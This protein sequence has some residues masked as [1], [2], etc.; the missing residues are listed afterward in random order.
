VWDASCTNTIASSYLELAVKGRGQV[1]RPAAL[2][3]INKYRNISEDYIF[4][5]F[6]VETLGPWCEEAITFVD[7]IGSILA[8]ETG[9]IHSKS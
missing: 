6:V 7:E 2:R 5:P 9:N 8:V 3:K 4:I 1:A